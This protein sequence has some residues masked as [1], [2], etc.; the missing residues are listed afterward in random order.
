MAGRPS[1]WESS[2]CPGCRWRSMSG[3]ELALPDWLQSPIG[4][5]RGPVV[6]RCGIRQVHSSTRGGNRMIRTRTLAA[7]TAMALAATLTACGPQS[8]TTRQAADKAKESAAKAAD[9]LKDAGKATMEAAKDATKAAADATADAAK[10]A[11]EAAKDATAKA[12]VA[13]KEGMA[14]AADATK[15][16]ADKAAAAARDAADKAKEAAKK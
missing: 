4:G 8:P 14:K 10:A 3:D 16:A 12:G 7:L 6:T 9:A 13:G 15:E 1:A 2:R 11:S 5:D